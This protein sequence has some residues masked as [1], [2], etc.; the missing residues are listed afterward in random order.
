MTNYLFF[1]ECFT[2]EYLL[3]H[4]YKEFRQDLYFGYDCLN[5]Y[6]TEKYNITTANYTIYL[7]EIYTGIPYQK[8]Y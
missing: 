4:T 7:N 5:K 8:K 1:D 6:L 2:K 3:T